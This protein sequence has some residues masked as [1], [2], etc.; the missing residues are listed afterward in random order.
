MNTTP[1]S[2]SSAH[3]IPSGTKAPRG[4]S[5]SM[6]TGASMAPTAMPS[7]VVLSWIAN[8]RA[9][10]RSSVARCSRVRPDTS[11]AGTRC[12]GRS[13]GRPPRGSATP[14]ERDGR[15]REPLDDAARTTTRARAAGRGTSEA[16]ANAPTSPPMPTD[17]MIRPAPAA[18][19]PR[20]SLGVGDTEDV[21]RTGE[22]EVHRHDAGAARATPSRPRA[23]R[24]RRA[25][26]AGRRPRHRP[27]ASRGAVGCTAPRPSRASTVPIAK[28]CQ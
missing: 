8:T 20:T 9:R 28:T 6:S 14:S 23:S 11:M 19:I 3:P 10:T 24:A 17:P 2:A 18:S 1:V 25:P 12:P 22:D 16:P 4:E 13:R 7:S 5:Q 26:R 15:E 21:E 27:R